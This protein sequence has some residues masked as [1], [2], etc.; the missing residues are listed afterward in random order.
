MTLFATV[1]QTLV[2]L[3]AL[4]LLGYLLRRYARVL[5][6]GHLP[7]FTGLVV[8]VTLPAL[9]LTE[10]VR[11]P[12]LDARLPLAMLSA[13]AVTMGLAFAVGR[14]LRLTRPALGM[15]LMVAC[16]GNTAFLGYPVSRAVVPDVFASAV[17]IDQFGMTLP[18][19]L[20]AGVLGGIFGARDRGDTGSTGDINHAGARDARGGTFGPAVQR[21]IRSPIFLAAALAVVV[22]WVP[23]PPALTGARGTVVLASMVG[24]TLDYLAKATTPVALLAMGALLQP[25]AATAAGRLLLVPCAFKLVVCPLL[26]WMVCR[27]LGLHG[28]LLRVGVL[29]ASMPTSITCSLLCA[30]YAMEGGL[31]GGAVFAATALSLVS[32]SLLQSLIR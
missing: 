12:R 31:A 6:L 19:L 27:L 30:Q 23:W 21:W 16:F 22:R 15:L 26:M 11:A 4:I 10:I 28:D 29:E 3:F 13:E 9:V 2:P 32:I 7:S 24:Q 5:H 20:T 17:V 18:M 25:R 14:L 1:L 8:N